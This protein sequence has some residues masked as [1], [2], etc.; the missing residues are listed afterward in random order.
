MQVRAHGWGTYAFHESTGGTPPISNSLTH[1]SQKTRL[2]FLYGVL[3]K[4]SHGSMKGRE[5]RANVG[6]LFATDHLQGMFGL[7]INRT[8]HR[9]TN[10]GSC[11]PYIRAGEEQLTTQ[12]SSR[13]I[14]SEQRHTQ[15]ISD[16]LR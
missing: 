8:D 7:W 13:D 4:P 6:P 16:V 14:T 2:P 12:V 1:R 3:S 11:L 5:E 10:V 9:T 15:S